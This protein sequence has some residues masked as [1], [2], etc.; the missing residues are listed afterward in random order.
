MAHRARVLKARPA[1]KPLASCTSPGSW[2]P[3]RACSSRAPQGIAH[4]G[5]AAGGVC[6]LEHTGPPGA[7]VFL[8]A[9]GQSVCGVSPPCV[10]TTILLNADLQSFEMRCLLSVGTAAQWRGWPSVALYQTSTCG[11]GDFQLNFRLASRCDGTVAPALLLGEL[12]AA[13]SRQHQARHVYLALGTAVL[14]VSRQQRQRHPPRPH[15]RR[16]SAQSACTTPTARHSTRTLTA[17]RSTS[18]CR[19]RAVPATARLG[20]G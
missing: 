11:N 19:R 15:A 20:P 6:G 9:S 5:P 14:L 18:T 10:H 4:T 16:A 1:K 7:S 17:T 13:S 12:R 2:R 3:A 8:R